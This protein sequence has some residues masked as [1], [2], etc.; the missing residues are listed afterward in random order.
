MIPSGTTRV[1]F[2]DQAAA[3]ARWGSQAVNSSTDQDS[4]EFAA[5]LKK[6]M[7]SPVIGNLGPYLRTM[8][9][10]GWNGLDVDWEVTVPS[11]TGAPVTVFKLRDDLDMASVTAGL[12]ARGE[13][14]GP[15]SRPT[16]RLGTDKIDGIVSLMNVTVLPDRHLLIAGA[17]PAD[18][19]AAIGRAQPD[20]I[21]SGLAAAVGGAEYLTIAVG[22]QACV[23]AAAVIGGRATTTA[24][25]AAAGQFSGLKPVTAVAVASTGDS[26]GTVVA[27]YADP[28]TAAADQQARTA[29][30]EDG[31]SVLTQ[32]PYAEL[33]GPATLAP[34]DSALRYEFAALPTANRL[35]QMTQRR[36]EPWAFCPA[37]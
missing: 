9:D 34:S 6:A 17:E 22:E 15:D 30:L 26:T 7:Q 35:A 8:T 2:T 16:Y 19:V 24:A 31:T 10:W 23:P 3:K 27:E 1:T 36:D 33:L 12:D 21:L 11:Q 32:Q 29:L 4:A 13:R 28:A 14:S 25:S 37:T 20:S 18:V 5:Y